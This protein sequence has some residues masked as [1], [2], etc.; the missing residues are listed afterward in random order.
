VP[1]IALLSDAALIA[2][3]ALLLS[4][5][6]LWLMPR[7][8]TAVATATVVIAYVAGVMHGLAAIWLLGLAA[9]AWSLRTARGWTRIIAIGATCVLG[10]FLGLHVLPGF[11]NPVIIREAVF[12]PRAL[13]YTQYVNFDKTLAAVLLL[14][15]SGWT[16]LRSIREWRH[17]LRRAAPWMLATTGAVMLGSLA[18]GFVR[19]EPHWSAAFAVWATIN[20]LTTCVSEETFFRGLIQEALPDSAGAVVVS[21]V[22]FGLAHLAG[23]WQYVLLATLAGAGYAIVYRLT[24]RLEMAILTHFALNAV[25]F[26][27]FTYPALRPA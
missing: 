25:H 3:A 19:F 21:A 1:S 12:T 20:V 17:A 13:P 23:G 11:S 7:A 16:P 2:V 5:L 14:G 15:G 8:S 26:L 6:S 18:L 9:G 4:V 22:L 27:L 10:L 24:A